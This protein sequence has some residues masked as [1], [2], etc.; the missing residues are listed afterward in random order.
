M[1]KYAKYFDVKI[2]T[3]VVTFHL[4]QGRVRS[5]WPGGL[6][7]SLSLGGN[8]RTC[9]HLPGSS[10][11]WLRPPPV[12]TNPEWGASLNSLPGEGMLSLFFFSFGFGTLHVCGTILSR[13]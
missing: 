3:T 9:R 12:P 13:V 1:I 8:E 7:L 11:A 10:M 6:S 5:A 2:I 4:S